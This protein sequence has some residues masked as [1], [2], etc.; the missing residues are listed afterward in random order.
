MRSKI[1]AIPRQFRARLLAVGD[2][3][4]FGCQDVKPWVE[5]GG[6]QRRNIECHLARNTPFVEFGS[7]QR[8]FKTPESVKVF[9]AQNWHF[10]TTHPADG[11]TGNLAK[12]MYFQQ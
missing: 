8:L 12:N 5:M 9:G 6:L 7:G 4:Y 3:E 10:G 2:M 11:D 1:S